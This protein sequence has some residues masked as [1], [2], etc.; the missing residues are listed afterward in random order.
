MVGMQLFWEIHSTQCANLSSPI[1]GENKFLMLKDII[2]LRSW[3]RSYNFYYASIITTVVVQLSRYS[4]LLNGQRIFTSST[5]ERRFEK[6]TEDVSHTLSF[7]CCPI[8]LELMG[9][10]KIWN[11]VVSMRLLLAYVAIPDDSTPFLQ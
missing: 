8:R 11:K 3:L 1:A 2:R 9:F 6:Y 5:I 4:T 7:C 10:G